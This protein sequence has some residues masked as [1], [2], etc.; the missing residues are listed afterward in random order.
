MCGQYSLTLT[1]TQNQD[2]FGEKIGLYFAWLCCYTT[3]LALAS[4]VGIGAYFF[5]WA[6]RT[7]SAFSIPFFALFMAIWGTIF[8]ERWKGRK[9]KVGVLQYV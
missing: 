3:Y 2:Y 4:V 7:N 8:L 1:L 5:V 9:T 6:Q